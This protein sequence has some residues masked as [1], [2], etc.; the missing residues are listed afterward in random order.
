[1]IPGEDQ[2]GGS[3]P[4]GGEGTEPL[5]LGLRADPAFFPEICLA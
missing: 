5:K 1:M 3:S 2:V 4:P